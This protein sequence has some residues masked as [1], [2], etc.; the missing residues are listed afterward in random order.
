M[1]G[2]VAIIF[3]VTVC[4]M[5][6][7]G[8]KCAFYNKRWYK[9]MRWCGHSGSQFYIGDLNGDRRADMLCH[10][11]SSGI[12]LARVDG[13]FS[14]KQ[15][16]WCGHS[17]EQLLLGDFNG[18]GRQDQL[19]HDTSTGHKMIKFADEYGRYNKINWKKSMRWC[20]FKTGRLFI[21]DF[22]GDNR[23]DM[24]C[25]NT[26]NGYKWIAL[27]D[28]N[29]HFHSTNWHKG[30]GWCHHAG[31]KLLIGDFNGDC[32]SDMMCHDSRGSTW[33]ALAK[34]APHIGFTGRGRFLKFSEL[35]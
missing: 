23:S 29:G 32:R 3:L 6:A 17:T 1:K 16:G 15:H 31:S 27:A 7:N 24:L 20:G 34:S 25:H 35:F 12:A 28:A 5:F 33:I 8:K 30:M 21:G 26:K 13:T 14:S 18:D 9:N 10:D 2:L 4:L 19:C 22:N 11:K